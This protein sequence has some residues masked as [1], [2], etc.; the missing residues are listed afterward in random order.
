LELKMI[1]LKHVNGESLTFKSN[2]YLVKFLF[3]H[4]WQKKYI[5]YLIMYSQFFGWRI[6]K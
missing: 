4:K 3:K 6:E 1:T 5:D 2:Y